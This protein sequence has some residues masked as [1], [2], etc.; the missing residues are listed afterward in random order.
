LNEKTGRTEVRQLHAHAWVEAYVN[1]HWIVL[2]PTP[3]A[4]DHAVNQISESSHFWADLVA[5]VR[6][7]WL[8]GLSL[9]GDQQRN[10]F[11]TP[12]ESSATGLLESLQTMADAWNWQASSRR[13]AEGA[14]RSSVGPTLMRLAAVVVL[15]AIVAWLVKRGPGPLGR[16][17]RK[18]RS[19]A[20]QKT[21]TVA[22]YE[23]FREI[24]A[25]SG[26][27]RRDS[28]TP[29]EFAADLDQQL[30]SHQFPDRIA[31]VPQALTRAF[32]Q[33]R[34]GQHVLPTNQLSE[35]ST[36]LDQFERSLSNGDS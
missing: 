11:L 17:L 2:D 24:L 20:L 35:L 23:R 34:F 10:L 19:R 5:S 27:Q 6:T 28:Q 9:T 26:H 4:R 18:S 7:F 31:H 30:R 8:Y 14:S 1:R 25:R 13:S 32:Y 36:S 29:R 33:V 3:A 22:F 12:L 16:R 15:L 21:Q